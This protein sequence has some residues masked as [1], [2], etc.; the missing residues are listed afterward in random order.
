[1]ISGAMYSMVPMKEFERAASS[2][3]CALARPKSLTRMWPSLSSST[4]SGFR[5]LWGETQ[6]KHS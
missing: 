1:M 5:S 6:R 4:F 2:C 3:M